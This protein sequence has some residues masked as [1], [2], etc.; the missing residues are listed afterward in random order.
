MASAHKNRVQDDPGQARAP[1]YHD[2]EPHFEPIHDA[3]WFG[4]VQ[5]VQDLLAWEAYVDAPNRRAATPL[6]L[7]AKL[8]IA[9][10]VVDILL[11]ILSKKSYMF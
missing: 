1:A 5:A 9:G 3:V 6:H 10:D 2:Y 4:R 11:S 8:G 7:A